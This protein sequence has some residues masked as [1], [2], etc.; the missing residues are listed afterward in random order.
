[1]NQAVYSDHEA[2]RILQVAVRTVRFWFDSGRLAGLQEQGQLD[3]QIPRRYLLYF[4]R[5][6]GLRVSSCEMCGQEL[7][8]V[9][10][11]LS[12]SVCKSCEKKGVPN[13]D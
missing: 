6:K 10:D 4:I 2:A 9:P 12:R 13:N 11:P 1:M 3:R 8:C 5:L 7:A